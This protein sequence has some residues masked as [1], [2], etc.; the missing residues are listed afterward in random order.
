MK[1]QIRIC[2]T[3]EFKAYFLIFRFT[4]TR[5]ELAV[6]L[7]RAANAET[8][9]SPHRLDDNK[10]RRFR[11][12]LAEDSLHH[13]NCS[14]PSG[15]KILLRARAIQGVGKGMLMQLTSKCVG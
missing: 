13:G 15:N 8:F 2:L 7:T 1:T 11:G 10:E 3:V 12:R 5:D 4:A 6:R 9:K 14:Y